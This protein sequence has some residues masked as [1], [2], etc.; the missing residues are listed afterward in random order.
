MPCSR[1]IR[2]FISDYLLETQFFLGFLLRQAQTTKSAALL[3]RRCSV[4][5]RNFFLGALSPPDREALMPHLREVSLGRG[6]VL[7]NPQDKIDALC[8]PGSACISIVTIMSD[9][10]AVE[11]ATVG[12]K[13]AVGLLDVMA[14]RHNNTRIFAQIGGSA[15]T[16]STSIFRARM[17]ERPG[18]LSLALDHARANAIQAEQGVACNVTHDVRQRLARWLLMTHDGTGSDTFP[19]TQDYMAAM[20]GVQRTTV[21]A[22]AAVLKREMIIDYS[23]GVITIRNRAK[24]LRAACECY[25][26]VG[27]QFEALRTAKRQAPA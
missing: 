23:R 16:L 2:I 8:F 22:T 15:M 18:L 19:L 24:L 3:G 25:V 12:R 26:I 10:R 11:V 7:Y 13:S 4:E 17:A 21:S 6:A 20:T 5:F 1:K 14:G 27:E 9:G